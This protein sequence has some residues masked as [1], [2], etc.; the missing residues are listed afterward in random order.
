VF[1]AYFRVSEG[2]TP[3]AVHRG[4]HTIR[5]SASLLALAIAAFAPSVAHADATGDVEIVK[6]Q[7]TDKV[8]SSN[9]V[10]AADQLTS[11]TRVTYWAAVKNAKEPTTIT[12]VW[13][14]DGQ[15][16]GRQ[17]LDVGTS[18]SWKTWGTHARGNA[19]S[20]EVDVLDKSGT[21]VKSD[22]LSF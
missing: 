5:S 20:I 1:S 10:A 22:T 2:G 4:M 17:T 21:Q 18:S 8:E 16:A 9:P 12:L 13:K 14:L 3:A 11:A 15:E 7:F 19:K 6:S